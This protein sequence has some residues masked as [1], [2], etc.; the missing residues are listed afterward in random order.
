MLKFFKKIITIVSLYV[1]LVLLF[2]ILNF[3]SINT[4][5]VK[6]LIF[7]IIVYGALLIIKI[8]RYESYVDLIIKENTIDPLT[9]V[10][11]R[12]YL[13]NS[14]NK[15]I[16]RKRRYKDIFSII[17]LDIDNFKSLNDAYGHLVGDKVLRT[18][19]NLL[20]KH[21]RNLDIPCRYG[22][23]EFVVILPGT[24]LAGAEIVANKIRC[25]FLK[26]T[27]RLGNKRFSRTLSGGIAEYKSGNAEDLI[28][29]ADKALYKAKKSGK[30]LI[31]KS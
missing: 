8:I 29:K 5:L 4:I 11:N 13:F 3:V 10:Y 16:Q 2:I 19:G 30:N 7:L 24:N 25:E 27:F 12:R 17:V 6:I 21:T 1:I 14:I 20:K 23:E 9:R 22:G 26:Y 28:K 18:L 31:C 15:E